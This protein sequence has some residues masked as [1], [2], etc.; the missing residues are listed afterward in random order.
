MFVIGVAGQAQMGKDTLADTLCEKLNSRTFESKDDLGP[1][2]WERA[3]FAHG[4]KDVFAN[5]FGVSR[6]FIEEWKVRDFPPPDFDM[7]VRKGLQFIGDGFRQIRSTI[8]VDMPFRDATPKII[9]DVRYPNEFKR[10]KEEGGLNIL[11]G[12]TDK[13]SDDPNGSEALIKP[14]VEWALAQVTEADVNLQLSTARVLDAG[15]IL[16]APKYMNRFHLFVRNDGT[17]DEFHD[18]IDNIVIPFVEQFSFN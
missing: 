3:S 1:P 13:L 14:Y 9:S 7:S 18:K 4:V 15:E 11:V 5:T 10:I 8:W 16:S 6:D 17:L 12:R 2:F